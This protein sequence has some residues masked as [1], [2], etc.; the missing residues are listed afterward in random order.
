MCVQ[1]EYQNVHELIKFLFFID[2][3]KR[4][5]PLFVRT[6]TF[7]LINV[8]IWMNCHTDLEKNIQEWLV[9]QEGNPTRFAN[10]LNQ[11]RKKK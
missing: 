4:D 5:G 1:K 2:L 3:H 6:S 7:G 11:N 10:L 8:Q 9:D